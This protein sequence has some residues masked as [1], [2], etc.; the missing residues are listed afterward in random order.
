MA[1][2]S[3]LTTKKKVIQLSTSSLLDFYN[4]SK[5]F[6]PPDF[7]ALGY[8]PPL[9][10]PLTVPIKKKNVHISHLPSVIVQFIKWIFS[11]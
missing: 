4:F 9:N 3:S 5:F 11:S 8:N 7:A 1:V 6:A 2:P 10:P